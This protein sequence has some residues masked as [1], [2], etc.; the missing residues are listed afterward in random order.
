MPLSWASTLCVLTFVLHHIKSVSGI[1]LSHIAQD[2]DGK[3]QS[4]NNLKISN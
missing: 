4:K 1:E 3:Y 2:D